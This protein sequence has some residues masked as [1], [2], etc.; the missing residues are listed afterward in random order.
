MEQTKVIRSAFKVG[1]FTLLSRLLGLIRDTLT[2]AAFGTSSAMSDFVVAFR[3]PNMFRALFGEGALSS[4]FIPVFIETR[5]KEGEAAAWSV[6]RKVISLV[7]LVLT[8]LVLIG[9]AAAT[10]LLRYPNLVEHAPMVL[11]LARIML[12]YMLFICLTALS[13]AILNSYHRFSLPAFTPSLLNI[14]WIFFVVAV[15]PLLGDTMDQ[16]IFGVAFGVFFAGLVQLGAQVPSMIRLGYRPGFRLDFKDARVLRFLALMG[17]TA[18]GQSVSQ[19]NMM[20]NGI[21]ARW[22][23]PWAPASL[24]FAERLLYFPQGILATALSTVLL[25]VFS[26]HAAQGNHDE[27]RKT[28]NHSLRSLLF[29][30]APASIGLLTLAEPITELVF[31]WGQFNRTS[32]AHTS[33]VLQFYAPGLFV[34][35]LAKVFVPA[36]YSLRDTRTPFL[37]G[38]ASV[39]TNLTMNIVFTIALPRDMK[40]PSLALAAVLSEGVNGLTLGFLLHRRL[41]SP[42]WTNILACVGRSLVAAILMGLCAVWTQS[43]LAEQI[44]AFGLPAKLALVVSVLVSIGGSVALYAAIAYLQRAPELREVWQALSQRTRKMTAAP[45]G[46]ATPET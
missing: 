24:Y 21:L 27:M 34:F 4:A 46:T 36:F 30:M 8:I 17:P 7:G 29:V 31:G 14:T 37:I 3:V 26:S 13:Q 23:A 25:P 2:A 5:Q 40:A 42:G 18:L 28:M 39:L 19:V 1:S 38:L 44:I 6:A 15:C 20:I 33:L 9:M 16:R 11:P 32:I 45:V 12:P 41:G 22:A 43:H 35:C 10:A